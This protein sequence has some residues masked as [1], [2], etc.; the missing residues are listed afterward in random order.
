M[1]TLTK[2]E[3]GLTILAVVIVTAG[4]VLFVQN[5]ATRHSEERRRREQERLELAVAQVRT[6][7]YLML[8]E[9]GIDLPEILGDDTDD[10]EDDEPRLQDLA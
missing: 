7:L 2:A 3:Y 6:E 4:L 8:H 9:R 10:A 5:L 1:V